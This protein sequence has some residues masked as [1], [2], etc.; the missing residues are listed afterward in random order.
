MDATLEPRVA[1]R[2]S[3]TLAEPPDPTTDRTDRP[4]DTSD[5]ASPRGRRVAVI[6][7][8]HVGLVVAAGLAELGHSVAGVDI[9]E[10]LVADL[11]EGEVHIEETGLPELV[12][13]NLAEGRLRF[14]SSYAV[15]VPEAEFIFLAVDTPST[16]AGAA[17][18]GAIRHAVRSIAENLNGTQPI[19]VNK[20]TSPIGTGE[21]IESILAS[22][23]EARPMPARIVSNPEFLRQGRAVEDFFAPDR[24]VVGSRSEADSRAVA[25]LFGKLDAEVIYTDLRTAEMIKYVA[26][27]YLATRISF[28]NEVARL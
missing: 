22:A 28:I 15:A 26:N 27:S 1:A 24:I 12:R 11:S 14:T 6:G 25:A 13:R 8:G 21:T 17:S 20:S 10:R 9:S 23:L 2:R 3:A 18:L 19:I 5:P 7:C 16:N 4:E